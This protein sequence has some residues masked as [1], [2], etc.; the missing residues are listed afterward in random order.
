MPNR[1]SI[2]ALRL[3]IA[4]FVVNSAV[5]YLQKTN[6][7]SPSVLYSNHVIDFGKI[8][9]AA[10]PPQSLHFKNISDQKLA[11]LLVEKGPDVI[12]HFKRIFF[13]PGEEGIITV[14]FNPRNTGMID[15]EI[16]LFN[17]IDTFPE[18]IKLKGQVVSITECFPDPG[19]LLKRNIKV[20][21]SITKQPVA[22]A[23]LELVHNFNI[24]SLQQITVD[25]KG[26]ATKELAIGQYSL[27]ASAEN[28][29]L[30]KKEFFLPKSQPNVI[31]EMSP[32]IAK[33][34]NNPE[35]VVHP[36]IE[37]A[38]EKLQ[39]PEFPENIYASNNVILLIDVS[40]SM[41][42]QGKFKLLQQAINNL[43][44]ILR[45]FDLVS[46]ITYS[47]EAKTILRS[48]PGNEKDRII[49]SIEALIPYG[50]TKGVKGLNAAYALAQVNF[51]NGGNNQ[52]I[53]AT[54][55]EFSDKNLP[56]SYYEELISGYAKKHICLSVFGFGVNEEAIRL[57]K[58]MTQ[59]GKGSFILIGSGEQSKEF[60]IDEIKTRSL[61]VK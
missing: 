27:T 44:L 41:K 46:V 6:G 15:E 54:D 47:G 17:N 55:G 49:D 2:C 25:K 21:D 20:I 1:D 5:I 51:I 42:S 59:A 4:F 32:Q 60:I 31:I 53:L 28:Y 29:K 23:R 30:L 34:V 43:V 12:V 56:D 13:L 19:N 48:V 3:L 9:S 58:K 45:P 8:A 50:I 16:R 39:Y 37:P 18:I 24:N 57:M 22:E 7:Q 11:I 14:Y 36:I 35:T 40:S 33:Q 52:V 10:N 61:I 26:Q 38:A